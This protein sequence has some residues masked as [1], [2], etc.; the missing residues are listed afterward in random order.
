MG[1]LKETMIFLIQDNTVTDLDEIPLP[2]EYMSYAII[3]HYY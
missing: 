3:L 2:I 1:D